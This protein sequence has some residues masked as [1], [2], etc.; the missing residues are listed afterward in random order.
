MAKYKG[1]FSLSLNATT[2]KVKLHRGRVDSNA[3]ELDTEAITASKL[4]EMLLNSGHDAKKLMSWVTDI[5]DES[6]LRKAIAK[7]SLEFHV[8]ASYLNKDGALVHPNPYVKD[9]DPESSAPRGAAGLK[10]SL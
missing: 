5:R 6:K 2:S 9:V 3:T 10:L 8:R 4:T 1:K 7:N